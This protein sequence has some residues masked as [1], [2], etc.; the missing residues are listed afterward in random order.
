MPV[1]Q[2]RRGRPPGSKNK[3]KYFIPNDLP[4]RPRG[5]NR[6]GPGRPPTKSGASQSL[7][8]LS[9]ILQKAEEIMADDLALRVHRAPA[10]T[11][12]LIESIIGVME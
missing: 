9:G 11:R 7:Q 3:T 1:V 10:K 5:Y 2:K 12:T 4:V 8:L 6:R